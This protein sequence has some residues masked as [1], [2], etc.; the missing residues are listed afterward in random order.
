MLTEDGLILC[1]EKYDVIRQTELTYFFKK[2]EFSKKVNQV[3]KGAFNSFAYDTEKVAFE[4]YIKRK[5]KQLWYSERS[6]QTATIALDRA[7]ECKKVMIREYGCMSSKMGRPDIMR[8]MW[9]D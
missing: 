9:F 5:E 7:R 4:S 8:D 2:W 6:R 1:L 3:R